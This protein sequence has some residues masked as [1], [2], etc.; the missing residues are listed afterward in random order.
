[1]PV[2]NLFQRSPVRSML[3]S[4][5][6]LRV[7][8]CPREALS[9]LLSAVAYLPNLTCSRAKSSACITATYD[10]A[11]HVPVSHPTFKKWTQSYLL[12]PYSPKT[13]NLPNYQHNLPR[14]SQHSPEKPVQIILAIPQSMPDSDE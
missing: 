12:Y 10:V 1:M 8:L 11:M 5:A 4:P 7:L 9:A 6:A 3:L 14:H 2:P 13:N